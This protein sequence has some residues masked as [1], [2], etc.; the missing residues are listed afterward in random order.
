MNK[1][2]TE[3][4]KKNLYLV[5]IVLYLILTIAVS[6]PEQ[7]LSQAHCTPSSSEILGCSPHGESML[8]L[9]IHGS[10]GTLLIAAGGRALAVLFSMGGFI[11]AHT[12][13]RYC[14]SFIDRVAEAGMAIPSLFLALAF[15]FIFEPG[16]FSMIL[17]ISASEWAINQKWILARLREYN[18]R[19]FIAPA[20]IAGAGRFHILRT[21]LFTFLVQDLVFLFFLYLPGSLLTVA[22]LEF[23][24]LS[25]SQA[26]PGLGYQVAAYKDLIFLYPHIPLPPVIFLIASVFFALHLKKRFAGGL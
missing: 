12:G 24:G 3:I 22:A 14:Y 16:F 13:G 17:A 7:N 4:F 26:I 15:G 21:H 18:R 23:L 25:A 6:E 10:L 1:P 20:E 8:S 5:I 11:L 9:L 2:L 19:G